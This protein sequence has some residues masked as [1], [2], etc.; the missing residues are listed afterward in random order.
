[1]LAYLPPLTVACHS[2]DTYLFIIDDRTAH[3]SRASSNWAQ[4]LRLR[5]LCDTLSHSACSY[6]PG[7]D[8]S[9]RGKL[10]E[11]LVTHMQLAEA[12]Y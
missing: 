2:I 12:A 11:L 1:M 8:W 9:R 6:L 4:V 7:K 10:L 5:Y 3:S